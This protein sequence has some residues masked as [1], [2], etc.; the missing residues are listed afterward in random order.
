VLDLSLNS[1]L[2]EWHGFATVE[3]Q[4]EKYRLKVKT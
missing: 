4:P 2:V 3:A 1:S